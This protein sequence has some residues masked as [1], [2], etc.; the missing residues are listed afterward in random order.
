MMMMMMAVMELALKKF[1]EM[2][3]TPRVVILV[4]KR[5]G[6]PSVKN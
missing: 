4:I 1:Q 6:L 3:F 5:T 2:H